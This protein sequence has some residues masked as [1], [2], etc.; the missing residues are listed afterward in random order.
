MN[1]DKLKRKI[2]EGY[3]D[4]DIAAMSG[5]TAEEVAKLR[6]DKPAAPKKEPVTAKVKKVVKASAA[7]KKAPG[8]KKKG[9]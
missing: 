4:E 5:M 9:K 8:G 6:T 3:T 2:K 7:T 1:L